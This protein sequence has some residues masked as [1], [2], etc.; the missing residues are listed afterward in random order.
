MECS[1]CKS[2]ERTKNGV[3]QGVQRYK[4]KSCGYNYT[5]EFR[6]GTKPADQKRLALLMYLE[7][8]GFR[9]IGRILNVHNTTVYR[10]IRNFGEQAEVVRN[11]KPVKIMKLDE[12]HTYVGHKKY[13]WIW[14][15]VSR[16]D[17]EFVDFVVGNRGVKTGLKLWE[18]VGQLAEG[19]VAADYWKPYNDIVPSE[20][21]VQT[22]AETYTVESY[23][24]LIKHF[25]ARFRR[26]SKCYSKSEEM[27]VLSL[28]LLFAQRNKTLNYI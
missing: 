4:C 13:R 27:I 2:K 19:M 10:W 24:G 15:C 6:R 3:L 17:R 8:L 7:G 28:K 23:N 14:T 5:V 20:K 16:D 1:R 9:S 22:K 11:D 26:K 21:L 18:K 12:F 25:L